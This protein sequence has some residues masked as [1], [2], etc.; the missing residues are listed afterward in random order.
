MMRRIGLALVLGIMPMAAGARDL[1]RFFAQ[2]Q[3][4][5]AR[6]TQVVR[7][8]HGALVSR[9]QGR[10]WL[11]RPGQFR[12]DY[13]TP[14]REQIVG[15]GSGVWIYDPGLAQATR[16]SLN[17]ALGRTPALLLAGRGHLSRL[18]IVQHLP[19]RDGLTWIELKP[20][21]AG[22]GFRWIRIGYKALRIERIVLRDALDQTTAIDLRDSR[23]NTA[24]PASLFRFQPPPHTAIV[25]E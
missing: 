6:F 23:L 18:F 16:Y 19:M 8:R 7:D 15:H 13:K 17:Q 10:L 12:W 11:K 5:K 25:R 21:G 24:L 1:S 9:G 2:V 3:T 14:Y 20:R 22:Q 4:L